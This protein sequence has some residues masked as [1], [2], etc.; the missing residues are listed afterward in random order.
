[1]NLDE[2]SIQEQIQVNVLGMTGTITQSMLVGKH[3]IA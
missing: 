3:P 1:M 2:N